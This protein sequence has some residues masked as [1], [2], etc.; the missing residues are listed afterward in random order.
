MN[1]LALFCRA[2]LRIVLSSGD[3]PFI[4]ICAHM[5]SDRLDW[6]QIK[7]TN[8]TLI[9]I[10]SWYDTFPQ[11]TF[12]NGSSVERFFVLLQICSLSE[13][14]FIL[15]KCVRFL[16]ENREYAYQIRDSFATPYLVLYCK[17]TAL[18]LTECLT[19][20]SSIVSVVTRYQFA[21]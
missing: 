7:N 5:I 3:V 8:Q 4:S 15:S 18:Y 9:T 6:T 11:M 20:Q 14:D 2:L 1:V 16:F 21:S 12:S 13:I 17:S 10:L 19:F